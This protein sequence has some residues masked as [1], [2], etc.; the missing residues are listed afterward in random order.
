MALPGWPR[1]KCRPNTGATSPTKP[2]RPGDRDACPDGNCGQGNDFDGKLARFEADRRG[3]VF[4]QG[5]QIQR[6]P[7]A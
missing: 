7:S 1:L 5:D 6:L 2:D 3:D 4:A